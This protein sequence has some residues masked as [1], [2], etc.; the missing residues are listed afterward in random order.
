MTMLAD[1][2]SARIQS[3][4]LPIGLAVQLLMSGAAMAQ[5]AVT[6][7]AVM[8]EPKSYDLAQ[9]GLAQTLR[10]IAQISGRSISFDESAVAPYKAGPVKGTLSA[11]AAVQAALAGSNW[12]LIEGANG[13][14][15][16]SEA[17]ESLSRVV[18]RAKRDQAELGFKASRSDTAS[19]SGS[20]LQDVPSAVAILT[21]KV[22]ETQQALSVQD[23]LANVSSVRTISSV[24]GRPS[25]AIR[26][27][28][29]GS[30][31]VNGLSNGST[32]PGVDSVQ[33]IEVLKGPQAILAGSSML[34]GA[35]NVVLKKPTAENIKTMS[36]QYGTNDDRTV[37]V[38]LAGAAA[39]DGRLS[40]RL[41]ASDADARTALGDV[42]Y[43][44]RSNSSVLPQLRWKDEDTDLTVSVYLGRRFNPVPAH[45]MAV[46]GVI[47]APPTMRLSHQDDGFTGRTKSLF[48]ALEQSLGHDITL[49]SRLNKSWVDISSQ[50][51]TPSFPYDE[52]SSLW[53]FSSGRQT[54]VGDSL[55]GDH[56]L[57]FKLDTGPVAHKLSVGFNHAQDTS[58][59]LQYS[60]KGVTASVFS[61]TPVDF[62]NT[63]GAASTL[64]HLRTKDRGVYVQDLMAFGDFNLLLGL[65]HNRYSQFATGSY[66]GL[67][68]LDSKVEFKQSHTTPSAGLVYKITPNLSSYV[69]YAQGFVP[70]GGLDCANQPLK[71]TTSTNKELGLKFET[72]D[73]LLGA[74]LSLFDLNQHNTAIPD[75]LEP[76]SNQLTSQRNK[77][78]EFDLQGKLATGL[79]AIVNYT[80]ARYTAP[81]S[82]VQIGDA[83][84]PKQ[85]ASVWA[86]YDF[87]GDAWRGWG[88][89]LGANAVSSSEGSYYL[90]DRFRVP[91]SLTVDMSLSYTRPAWSLRLGMKDAFDAE[92]FRPTQLSSFVPL[93]PGRSATLTWRMSFE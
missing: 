32:D 59:T 62:P 13:S 72:S 47:Q 15:L 58:D 26:G 91:G 36:L 89:G 30:G 18:V 60:G 35:V 9:G 7:P 19:R 88:M 92:R 68:E 86:T 74:T 53:R 22:L 52:T 50:V 44:G 24:Q 2:R 27:Y 14:L 69:N 63:I 90:V 3:A 64:S 29:Q 55:T 48:Y 76:C 65:R 77:G 16:V 93:A 45:T 1:I 81:E 12:Q 8:A 5:P 67:P 40:Y 71:A 4:L 17:P 51:F 42:G 49:V 25:Y 43:K 85:K 20:D 78:L 70:T 37:A 66:V 75:A 10:Q 87:Q 39:A 38:D 84:F 34:G 56:Y 83:S 11:K 46:G 23:A 73:G 80:Y 41:N 61:P 21:A 28:A 33:R 31:L 82:V 6:V 79:N 57:R 54:N